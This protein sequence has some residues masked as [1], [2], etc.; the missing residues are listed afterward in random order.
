MLYNKNMTKK[1]QK[2]AERAAKVIVK[3]YGETLKKLA[4]C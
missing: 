1:E 2:L 3:N 4:K